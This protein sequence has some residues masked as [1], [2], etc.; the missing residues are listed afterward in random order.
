MADQGPNRPVV[1]LAG[2]PPG[3]GQ[4]RTARAVAS[5]LGPEVSVTNIPG[6]GGGNCWDEIA[7]RAGHDLLLAVSSPTLITNSLLGTSEIDDRDLTPIATLYTEYSVVIT[8]AGSRWTEPRK[9]LEGLSAGEVT[10]SFATAL[11]NMNHLALAELAR[12]SGAQT[13]K[14]PLRIFESARHVVAD[15]VAGN[16]NVA[17]VSTASAI[18]ELSEGTVSAL[19]VTAPR[20]LGGRFAGVPTWV[21]LQVPCDI[22]TWRGLVGPP[23]LTA[24]QTETWSQRLSDAIAGRG[25]AGLLRR[26]L[27]VDAYLGPEDTGRFL[28]GER[29]RLASLLAEVGLLQGVGRG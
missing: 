25:W 20:R 14:M 5:V 19:A 8:Q 12:H 18:P 11:G 27:W 13:P 26:H 16:A 28:D 29:R 3:G 2:T 9:V 10:V 7:T 15:L 23:A 1:V 6:R 17:I 22:G 4:D 24:A 21:E